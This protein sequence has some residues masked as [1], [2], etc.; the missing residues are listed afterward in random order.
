MSDSD[1]LLG[2]RLLIAAVVLMLVLIVAL[3]V[4]ASIVGTRR[5]RRVQALELQ[6]PMALVVLLSAGLGTVG[7]IVMLGLPWWTW[8]PAVGVLEVAVVGYCRLGQQLQDAGDVR[9]FALE[10]AREHAHQADAPQPQDSR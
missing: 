1:I 2:L 10:A 4:G 8:F 3:L 7:A 9:R 5:G 6:L